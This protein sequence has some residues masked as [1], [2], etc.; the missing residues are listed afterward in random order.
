M[1]IPVLIIPV[2]NR[3]DLLHKALESID[4]PIDEILIINNSGKSY[5]TE[6]LPK[7]FSHLNIRT[8]DMPSNMGISGSWNLGIKCYPHA[9]YWMISSADTSFLP[10]SLE[11]FANES[12]TNRF[13]KSSAAYSCFSLGEE[14][15]RV[16][17]LFDE[18][19]YPAYFEDNDYED[20]MIEAGL[21]YQISNAGIPV[22]DSGGS[23]TIK[24]DER[25]MN[26]NHETFV[27][28][29]DYYEKKKR[30]KDY[31]PRGWNLDRRR[32]N[33]WL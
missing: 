12:G 29:Q 10:G 8:L 24:S 33:E 18:Y 15:V 30:D 26:K 11:R 1:S 2:L 25:L 17:G 5:N 22:D 27:R 21:A 23:M 9:K 32:M 7:K 31:T 14:I 19:I 6:V 3:F 28:N 16:V 4:Y 13:V 20:R